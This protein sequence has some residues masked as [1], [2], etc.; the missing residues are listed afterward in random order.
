MF[1]E[2]MKQTLRIYGLWTGSV[3]SFGAATSLLL[4]DPDDIRRPLHITGGVMWHGIG[5]FLATETWKALSSMLQ[6]K[7]HLGAMFVY[8]LLLVPGGCLSY[9]CL[10]RITPVVGD[11]FI[12]KAI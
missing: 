9:A 11:K 12:P 3:L 1:L 8:P 6:Q 7:P 10:L 4:N 5:M 2:T